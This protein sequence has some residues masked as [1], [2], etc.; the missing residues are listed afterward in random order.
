MLC[1]V[2]A[3]LS[4]LPRCNLLYQFA[5][6][7]PAFEKAQQQLI[8][9]EIVIELDAMLLLPRGRTGSAALHRQ[10]CRL[11]LAMTASASASAS[12]GAPRHL[13][14]LNRMCLCFVRSFV[15]SLSPARPHIL[16]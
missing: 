1:C 2:C 5:A 6:E 8:V 4:S 12:A 7:H 16:L 13:W 3:V 10:L 11:D 9:I 15:R 14:T